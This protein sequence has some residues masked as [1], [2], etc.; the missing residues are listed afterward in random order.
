MTDSADVGASASAATTAVLEGKLAVERY[1]AVRGRTDWICEPLVTEDFV[2]QTMSDVSPTKWH[3]AH[4][5]WFFETFILSEHDKSYQSPNP[6]YRFLYNSYYNT[7]GAQHYRPHRGFLSRPTVA[8]IREYRAHVD[9]AMVAFLEQSDER[10]LNA[11]APVLEIGL[12]HEQQHQELM[13]TDIKHVFSCNPL[14]PAYR[15][16]AAAAAPGPAS[17]LTW[18]GRNEGVASIGHP[19]GAFAYDNESPRHKVYLAEHELASRLVTNR[20]YAQF[21]SDG[22]YQTPELWLSEGWA[23]VQSEAWNSPLY[24]HDSG[25]GWQVFTLGGLRDVDPDE[26]VCHVSYFEADAFARWAGARLPTE[27]EWETAAADLPVEGN[28]VDDARF[29]PAPETVGGGLR[30]MYGDVWEWTSSSYSPYP[31]YSPPDGALGE[32]NG[33]FMCNQYVLRGGSCATSHNHIRPTYRNFFP[34][35]SRWQFMGIRLARSL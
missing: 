13:V 32:Y 35:H 17:E 12:H 33:K 2:V 21:M 18:V 15:A 25:T 1:K 6:S 3:L 27:A 29:H 22:G 7:V 9:A 31:G 34:P 23:T 26:P 4:T 14:H 24:W 28:F 8:D 10:T 20:E 19:D 16:D 5:S 11:I 30:Q